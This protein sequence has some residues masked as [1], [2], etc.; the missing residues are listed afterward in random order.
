[1]SYKQ[2]YANIAC[3]KIVIATVVASLQMP[4]CLD[5]HFEFV[6]RHSKNVIL[7]A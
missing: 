5:E 1:M 4:F 2:I 6:V 7:L 3:L